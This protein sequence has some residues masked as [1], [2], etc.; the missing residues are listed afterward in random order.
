[1]RAH[2]DWIRSLS[3]S[4]N[5]LFLACG[6]TDKTVKV[7]SVETGSTLRTLHGH[8]SYVCT[9]LFS[10]DSSKVTSGSED[11]TLRVWRLFPD[12]ER[13]MKSL[14]SGVNISTEDQ[15]ARESERET[16]P[17]LTPTTRTRPPS[18]AHT[19]KFLFQDPEA[20]ETPA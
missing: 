12:Q 15:W 13:K 17:S 14:C 2:T 11:M 20:K 18:L 8:T 19:R 10:S 16:A 9:V 1:M 7:L 6:S 3:F 5:G 4:P